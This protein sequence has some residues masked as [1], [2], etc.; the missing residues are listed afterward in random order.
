M[1][2]ERYLYT[3][4]AGGSMLLRVCVCL[5]LIRRGNDNRPAARVERHFRIEKENELLAWRHEAAQKRRRGKVNSN[6]DKEAYL[7]IQYLARDSVCVD[8]R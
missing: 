2:L 4:T 3:S 6:K 7:M 1:D 5:L 8:C